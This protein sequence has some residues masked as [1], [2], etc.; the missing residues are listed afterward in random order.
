MRYRRDINGATES[1][2][3]TAR[4]HGPRRDS[5]DR[6]PE[7]RAGTPSMS[8]RAKLESRFAVKQEDVAS[9]REYGRKDH[10]GV[11][12]ARFQVD[13]KLSRL[14]DRRAL[15]VGARGLHQRPMDRPSEHLHRDEVEHDRADN[16]V[17]V[18]ASA[19]I[20]ADS[21]PE[22]AGGRASDENRKNG[23]D[24]RPSSDHR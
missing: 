14:R 9:Y 15:R 11:E 4:C 17:D 19:K 8:K 16:F 20:S 6:N 5:C 10:P 23:H 2:E 1:G 12:P 13:M 18:A 7:K 24:M 22:G 21:A 3:R